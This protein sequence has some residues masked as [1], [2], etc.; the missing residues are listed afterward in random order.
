MEKL[1]EEITQSEAVH[2]K[3]PT[4]QHRMIVVQ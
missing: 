1:G 3:P 4:Y 2:A